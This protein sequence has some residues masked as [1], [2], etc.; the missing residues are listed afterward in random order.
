MCKH[1][2]YPR[3]PLYYR[4]RHYELKNATTYPSYPPNKDKSSEILY[5]VEKAVGRGV[6]FMNNVKERMD[7]FFDKSAPSIV[8]D[9]EE[10]RERLH[11]HQKKGRENK[12]IHRN[13]K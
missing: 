2:Y 1:R 4:I 8:V 3:H 11:K 5:G 12:G 6:Y 10:Y 9:I 13:Y 7:I